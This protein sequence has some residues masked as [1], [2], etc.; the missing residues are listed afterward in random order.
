MPTRSPARLLAPLALAAAVV[1]VLV[2]LSSSDAD[3]GSSPV[4]PVR[5]APASATATT[6]T[7]HAAP[8]TYTVRPGDTLTAIADRTGVSLAT[9]QTLNA[10]IDANSLHAGQ[11]LKLRPAS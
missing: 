1:A 8:A 4:T 9:L 10:R 5:R 3:P 7:R 11:K 6:A 2:V